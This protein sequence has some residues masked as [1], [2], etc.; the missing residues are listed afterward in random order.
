MY[1]HLLLQ[2]AYIYNFNTYD[3][4]F[5]ATSSSSFSPDQ[6]KNN[7]IQI[8][9]AALVISTA[10]LLITGLITIATPLLISAAAQSQSVPSN[11]NTTGSTTNSH[12]Y[13]YKASG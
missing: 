6:Y 7:G 12:Y 11:T 8:P 9:I 2:K 4:K 10:I 5:Y 3:M 1:V 13:Y